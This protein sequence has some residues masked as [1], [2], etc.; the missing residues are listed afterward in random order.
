[1]HDFDWESE[2]VI[3]ELKASLSQNLEI[4]GFHIITNEIMYFL[5]YS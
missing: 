1:M 2:L 3:I 4:K 5:L